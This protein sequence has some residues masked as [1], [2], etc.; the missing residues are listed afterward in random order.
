[1]APEVLNGDGHSQ[2]CDW[3]SVGVILYEMVIGIPPFYAE[4]PQETQWKVSR[5]MMTNNN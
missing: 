1:M 5:V 2:L 4:T 3:W